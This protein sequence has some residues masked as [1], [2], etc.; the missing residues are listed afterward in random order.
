MSIKEII[1]N[2]TLGNYAKNDEWNEELAEAIIS[3]IVQE[4]RKKK[5]SLNDTLSEQDYDYFFAIDDCIET[6]K[7]M[8]E[9]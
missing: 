1:K 7:E 2:S 6:I 9:E 3:K 5:I 4:L 8:R